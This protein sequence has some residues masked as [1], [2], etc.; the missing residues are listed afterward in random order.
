M[1][2]EWQKEIDAA[3]SPSRMIGTLETRKGGTRGWL[4]KNEKLVRAF[5]D[6]I[7]PGLS[8]ASV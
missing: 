7:I 4:Q 3:L 1:V 2:I 6:A 5:Y 8:G